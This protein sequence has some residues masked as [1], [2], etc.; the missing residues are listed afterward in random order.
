MNKM[1]INGMLFGER[2]FNFEG[3]S[4]NYFIIDFV[5][6]HKNKLMA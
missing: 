4:N 5:I 6:D 3:I 2:T 1:V